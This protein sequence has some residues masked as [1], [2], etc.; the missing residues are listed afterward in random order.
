[1][2]A[3]V[4]TVVSM[5]PTSQLRLTRE[6]AADPTSTAL[7]L[8]GPTALDLWPGVRRTGNLDGLVRIEAKVARKTADAVVRAE[9]PR[10]L[11]T[12]FVTT[13]SVEV[14]GDE[15]PDAHGILTLQYASGKSD[16]AT[17]AVLEL[18]GEQSVA[19]LEKG[20]KTFL[21]NLAKAAEKRATAA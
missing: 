16:V 6:I 17:H 15:L 18:S 14:A 8:A 12:S 11:P 13:F 10:R 7:L 20:A 5:S 1:M 21:D 2:L 19:V 4:L 3:R 9:P